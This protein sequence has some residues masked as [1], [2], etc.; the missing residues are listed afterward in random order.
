MLNVYRGNVVLDS[1]G[2]ATVTLPDYFDAV[3]INFSYNLTSIGSKS[4]VFIKRN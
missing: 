4:E 1:N 2:E 3:N